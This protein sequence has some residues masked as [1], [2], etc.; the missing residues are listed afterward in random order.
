MSEIVA[1]HRFRGGQGLD[2]IALV[3]GPNMAYLTGLSFS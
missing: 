3:P 1:G 2:A